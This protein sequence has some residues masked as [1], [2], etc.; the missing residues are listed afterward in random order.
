MPER[1][2]EGQLEKLAAL[3]AKPKADE[4]MEALRT[5]LRDRVNLVVA[6]AAQ[7]I[8]ELQL[9]QL[10]PDLISAFGRLFMNSAKSDAQCWGKNAIAKALKDLD[11]DESAPF[12]RGMQH[13]QMEP[14]WGTTVDTAPTLRGTSALALLQCSDITRENK[15]W[16]VMRLLSDAAAP[17]RRDAAVCLQQLGGVESAL[18]LRLKARMG[19]REPPVIGQVLESILAIEGEAA[20]PFAVEFLHSDD[21]EIRE[22]AALALG[23][24]RLAG[25]VPQ[26]ADAWQRARDTMERAA[27][28]RAMAASRQKAAIEFIL[29]VLRDAREREAIGALEALETYSHSSD[30]GARILEVVETRQERAIQE[31]FRQHLQQ[32]GA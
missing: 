16:H 5:A 32:L 24:S 28:L 18:L 7:I 12:L 9:R 31:Y 3:R 13:I 23:A 26:L 30:V 4:T 1:K 14:V 20:L 6:K 15:I 21:Q 27:I 8:G 11:Y 29:G 2:I 22:E 25:S 19:D 17:V 10:T